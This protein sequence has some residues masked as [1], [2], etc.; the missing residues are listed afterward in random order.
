MCVWKCDVLS[1]IC[2][3][4]TVVVLIFVHKTCL[5]NSCVQLAV[6]RASSPTHHKNVWCAALSRLNEQLATNCI[7]R[8]TT[9]PRTCVSGRVCI[10]TL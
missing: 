8:E 5:L 3:Y 10:F 6:N 1:F 7:I 2:K 9:E 4:R